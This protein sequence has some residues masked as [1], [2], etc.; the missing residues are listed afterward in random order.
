MAKKPMAHKSS[1][2]WKEEKK[3]V[4]L[5]FECL[6]PR[7][8]QVFQVSIQF[9]YKL[10]PKHIEIHWNTLKHTLHRTNIRWKLSKIVFIWF[11]FFA[12]HTVHL[13]TSHWAE[14]ST[15]ASSGQTNA[16]LTKTRSRDRLWFCGPNKS[17]LSQTT[18]LNKKKTKRINVSIS[19]A[20]HSLLG[21]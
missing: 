8:E 3:I 21:V 16:G 5:W 14:C 13:F 2:K 12:L 1:G 11:G 9:H 17:R 19:L 18:K 15:T 6:R 20:A 7:I 10:T 4:R